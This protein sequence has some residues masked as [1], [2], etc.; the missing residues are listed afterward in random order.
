MLGI[1]E[2]QPIPHIPDFIMERSLTGKTPSDA[3]NEVYEDDI[4]KAGDW[5]AGESCYL[6]SDTSAI[7]NSDT[8]NV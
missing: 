6:Y 4:D 2:R 8:K 5:F 3:A 1:F 7:A